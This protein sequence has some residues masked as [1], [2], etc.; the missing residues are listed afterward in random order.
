MCRV[1]ICY[2]GRGIGIILSSRVLKL[3]LSDGVFVTLAIVAML[4]LSGP[5]FDVVSPQAGLQEQLRLWCQSFGQLT[6][7]AQISFWVVSKDDQ[8]TLQWAMIL[9]CMDLGASVIY[10]LLKGWRW[11][12]SMEPFCPRPASYQLISGFEPAELVEELSEQ[13]HETSSD[14]SEQSVKC[15]PEGTFLPLPDGGYCRVEDLQKDDRVKAA[16]GD[17]LRITNN[18]YHVAEEPLVN[19]KT[20][21]GCSLV[22]TG[23]HRIVVPETPHGNFKMASKLH[24]GD[25]ISISGTAGVIEDDVVSAEPMESRGQRVFKIR[26][27]PDKP[28]ESF[29]LPEYKVL[30]LGDVPTRRGTKFRGGRGRARPSTPDGFDHHWDG[31]LNTTS[32]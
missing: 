5:L 18:K 7:L 21:G 4:A 31:E 16:S 26:F 24:P 2:Y 13:S 14:S 17:E 1:I 3:P 29:Q 20:T 6:G 9:F 23:N 22:V 28:I 12:T 27:V 11:V 15:F 10:L 8:T 25:K 19:I 30:S 32:F